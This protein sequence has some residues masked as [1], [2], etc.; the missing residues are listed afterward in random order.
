MELWLILSTVL[1]GIY[2]ILLTAYLIVFVRTKKKAAQLRTD[3]AKMYAD[4]NLAK[5]DYDF[6]VCDEETEELINKMQSGEGQAFD[7]AAGESR[8]ST[9]AGSVFGAVETDG[10]EEITGNYKP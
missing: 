9:A 8:P 6:C 4:P 5:M 7:A 2:V 10:L 3:L 1:G